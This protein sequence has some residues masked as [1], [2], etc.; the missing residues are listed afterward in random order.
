MPFLVGGDPLEHRLPGRVA[1]VARERPVDGRG[2]DL[3]GQRQPPPVGLLGRRGRGL[4]LRG[5][6]LGLPA[7][8]QCFG[9]TP[10]MITW[11]CSLA[12][13]L[14]SWRMFEQSGRLLVPK[15]RTNS[16]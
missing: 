1:L 15:A 11:M 10:W 13:P 7:I 12:A 16:W 14:D 9:E 3:L 4:R 6:A 5:Q 8:P 2:V